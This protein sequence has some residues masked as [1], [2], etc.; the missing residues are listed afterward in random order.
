MP[1]F[2]V[3]NFWR[4]F[5]FCPNTTTLY[6]M[7]SCKGEMRNGKKYTK[8]AY[9]LPISGNSGIQKRM[10]PTANNDH[11]NHNR[12]WPTLGEMAPLRPT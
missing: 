8:V 10:T 12:P 9:L 6:L 7:F 4:T 5:S 1:G 11:L 2:F 3:I